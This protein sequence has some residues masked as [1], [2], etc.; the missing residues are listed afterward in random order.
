MNTLALLILYASHNPL[1]VFVWIFGAYMVL[2][3]FG[4]MSMWWDARR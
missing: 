2:A 1:H 4:W 3:G